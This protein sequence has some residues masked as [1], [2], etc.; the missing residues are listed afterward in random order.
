[1]PVRQRQGIIPRSP[2]ARQ[3]DHSRHARDAKEHVDENSRPGVRDGSCGDE[4]RARR[5][6]HDWLRTIHRLWSM[7]G[8]YGDED[9]E[10]GEPDQTIL[11]GTALWLEPDKKHYEDMSEEESQE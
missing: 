2:T 3:R 9:V 7:G 10:L 8:R 5:A 1:M 6:T 11:S 4:A